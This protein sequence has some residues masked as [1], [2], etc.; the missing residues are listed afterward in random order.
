MNVSTENRMNQTIL[1]Y[2]V[3]ITQANLAEVLVV[4]ETML[5]LAATSA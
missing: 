5:V 4:M 1:Q 2:A 3:A